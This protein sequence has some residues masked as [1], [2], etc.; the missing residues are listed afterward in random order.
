MDVV[1]DTSGNMYYTGYVSLNTSQMLI[2]P[3]E[4]VMFDNTHG[5]HFENSPFEQMFVM[6]MDTS[7]TIQWLKQTQNYMNDTTIDPVSAFGNYITYSKEE[8]KI[9]ISGLGTPKTKANPNYILFTPID[10][11]LYSYTRSHLSTMS[12]IACYDTWGNFLWSKLPPV[13]RS[14][15]IGNIEYHN[16]SLSAGLRWNDSIKIQNSWYTVPAGISA[17]SYCKWDTQGNL[18]DVKNLAT[19]GNSYPNI[20]RI[21]Q[22]G[23]LWAGG[24]LDN[25]LD[26][27]GHIVSDYGVSYLAR[28]NN[29]CSDTV[30]NKPTTGIPDT[31]ICMNT[32]IQLIANPN[33]VYYQW[34]NGSHSNV[35]PINYSAA[36]TDSLF[37]VVYNG[38][39]YWTDT[40]VVHINDCTGVE[41]TKENP[42][43]VYPNPADDILNISMPQ[44]CNNAQL[45][46]FNATGQIQF[47]TSFSSKAYTLDVS[48][49]AP[50][51]YVVLLKT[52]ERIYS[53]KVSV[54]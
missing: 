21:D 41:E 22:I 35:Y 34:Q 3:P 16:H 36:G 9:F 8:N 49:Y 10:T 7:G 5:I 13:N 39:C 23:N 17:M 12:Y 54:K 51:M 42:L 24:K 45:I 48:H 46:L 38:K 27:G 14:C 52:P 43:L 25:S 32:N 40:I 47:S 28:F 26:F 6:K 15:S 53:R 31:I 11:L 1:N 50:G 18:L 30:Q 37:A 20:T 2:S 19:T 4:N 33:N 44:Y 29:Q